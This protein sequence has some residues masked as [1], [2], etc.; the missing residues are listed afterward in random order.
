[1]KATIDAFADGKVSPRYAFAHLLTLKK[2]E[3][4][5]EEKVASE[6]GAVLEEG[7]V[8]KAEEPT[9]DTTAA[10]ADSTANN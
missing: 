2:V 10:A 9:A 6:E 7:S 3:E 5:K 1:V 8:L 4:P